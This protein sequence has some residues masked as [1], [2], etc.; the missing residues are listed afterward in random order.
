MADRR[1]LI[2]AFD[3]LRPD[4][5]TPE[6]MPNLSRFAAGGVRFANNRSTYPTETRVNQTA[7]VTGA[8]PSRHGIVGNQFLDLAASPERL[9]NTGD[10]TALSAGDRRL[11]GRL[12]DTPV[13]SEILREA[14]EE[15]A[16]V[17]AGTPGG[18]RILNHKAEGQG[19]FRLALKRP[20]ASVP[21]DRVAAAIERVGPIPDH[22]IPTLEWLTY[23]TDVYLD[24]IEPEIAPAVT[25]LWYCE[26]DNSYHHIGIG[27]SENLAAIRQVDAELGRI[28]DWRSAQ[29]LEDSLQI[30]TLSDH[31]QISVTSKSLDVAGRLRAAGFSVGD[32]VG[33][34]QDAILSLSS[35]GGL[36]VRNSDPDLIGRL[37]GWLQ[38]QP[39]CGPVFTRDGLGALSHSQIGIAH[40]RAPDIGFVVASDDSENAHGHAGSSLQNGAYPVGGGLHGGLN[41]KELHSW[42]AVGG[43]AFAGGRV[44][45]GPSGIID[46]LPT[47]LH[48]LGIDVPDTV[49]GRLLS[50]A[51]AGPPRLVPEARRRTFTAEGA[52]GYRAHLAVS[53]VGA[54]RYLDEAWVTRD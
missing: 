15:L 18:C 23:T 19:A 54:T 17:S 50:E 6:L 44:I 34:E 40:R 29:G 7:L 35:A 32:D 27:T 5:V 42:L 52:K 16:V 39:W 9:F 3:A 49:E 22:R 36:Y 28:L 13:L 38:A 48:L 20:D 46:V 11:N 26:P 4:M 51:L 41:R 21:P 53:L 1:V 33:G 10:E 8:S 24:Y 31:G 47:V 12:V 30:V 25:I 45:E 37:V 14:G 2:V 43:S